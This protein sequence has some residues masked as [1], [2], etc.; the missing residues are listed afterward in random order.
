[1]PSALGWTKRIVRSN[2]ALGQVGALGETE[3]LSILYEKVRGQPSA[4]LAKR[5]VSLGRARTVRTHPVGSLLIHSNLGLSLS[6]L[7]I[8][9]SAYS[10]SGAAWP[11]AGIHLGCGQ[12]R[13]PQKAEGPLPLKKGGRSPQVWQWKSV[14]KLADITGPRRRSESFTSQAGVSQWPHMGLGHRSPSLSP[15]P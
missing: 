3:R 2:Q 6:L 15:S 4:W 10:P 8:S 1:M 7:T 5:S 12:G 9:A 14:K 11:T 13:L